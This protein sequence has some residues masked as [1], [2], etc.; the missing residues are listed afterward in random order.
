MKKIKIA[1]ILHSV[2]GVDV[3]LRFI[4]ENINTDKFETI[5][6][7]GEN[8][9]KDIYI[10]RNSNPLNEYRVSIFRDISIMQDIKA[11]ISV[12]KIIKKERPNLIHCHSTKG[13]II[14]RIV[15]Y[16]LNINVLHTPQAFS[17]L[18]T[19]NTFKKRIL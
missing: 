17:F 4:L 19:N 18:S 14:G 2:G 10:D 12:Y 8:D 1:H 9:T 7:H 6:V 13:G 5:V 3:S 11:L 16:L 15:G